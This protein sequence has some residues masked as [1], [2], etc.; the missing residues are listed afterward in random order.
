MRN[1][2][3][4]WLASANSLLSTL[5]FILLLLPSQTLVS[6]FWFR[7]KNYL[8]SIDYVSGT[9]LRG[10]KYQAPILVLKITTPKKRFKATS[11]LSKLSASFLTCHRC[12]CGTWVKWAIA[13]WSSRGSAATRDKTH[14]PNNSLT[15]DTLGWVPT[16]FYTQCPLELNPQYPNTQA[17]MQ[18]ICWTPTMCQATIPI[19][20]CLQCHGGGWG[21]ENHTNNC[22]ITPVLRDTMQLQKSLRQRVCSSEARTT[23]SLLSRCHGASCTVFLLLV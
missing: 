20:K 15:S 21:Q 13:P 11:S 4:C 22:V 16:N 3:Q 23:Y 9:M 5:S 19:P 2:T 12:R 18:Q 8:M 10:T 6:G 17:F 1:R 7:I 14:L